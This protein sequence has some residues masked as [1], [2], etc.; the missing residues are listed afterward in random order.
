MNAIKTFTVVARHGSFKGAADELGLT[1]GAVAQQ[2]RSLEASLGHP[3]FN[4]EH[5]GLSLSE[6]GRKLKVPATRAM[7]MIDE[8]LDD[9]QSP[10][11]R[12]SL[13]VPPSFAA[14][15]L[16]PR[17]G[18]FTNQY[19]KVELK[20][21]A[22]TEVSSFERNEAD[23]A[24]RICTPV[25]RATLDCHHL[26]PA[27]VYP[28]CSPSLAD[29]LGRTALGN[30]GRFTLLQDTHDLWRTYL[31]KAGHAENFAS[32]R[33]MTF[34]QASLAIDAAIA[35]QGIAL[36]SD[37]LVLEDVKAGR[38]VAP[39]EKRLPDEK[40]FHLIYPRSHR[41]KKALSLIGNWILEEAKESQ[42]GNS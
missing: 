40:G 23:I 9:I 18:R 19:P 25:R 29:E 2:I 22:T 33:T 6:A 31:E 8:A 37:P 16:I 13:S 15:W 36:G 11:S 5:K 7:A 20:V 39:F 3:L 4:R 24:V 10:K 34:S 30:L 28:V 17:L 14:K 35:G 32:A 38:L 41:Q 1:Q 42:L 21:L 27:D 26:F 12:I